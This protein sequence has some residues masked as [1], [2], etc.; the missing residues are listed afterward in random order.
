MEEIKSL[1]T[2]PTDQSANPHA[3][4][5][6]KKYAAEQ[7]VQFS[8]SAVEMGIVSTINH[9][10]KSYPNLEESTVRDWRNTYTYFNWRKKRNEG[11]ILEYR[12]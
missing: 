1:A 9:F 2:Q 12:N 4:G 7:K 11:E 8:K 6:Y 5:P 3:I 10:C